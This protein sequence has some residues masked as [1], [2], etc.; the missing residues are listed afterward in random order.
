MNIK[1]EL[2]FI[3]HRLVAEIKCPKPKLYVNPIFKKICKKSLV[4]S[5][6]IRNENDYLVEWLDHHLKLGIKLIV[7]YDNAFTDEDADKTKNLISDYI[8]NNYVIYV[9]WPDLSGLRIGTVNIPK[10]DKINIAEIAHFHFRRYLSKHIGSRYFLKL[11]TDEFIYKLDGSTI[12]ESDLNYGITRIVGYNFGSSGLIKFTK[13]KVLTK[14]INRSIEANHYKAINSLDTTK[15]IYDAHEDR[16]RLR[17]KIY[18]FLFNRKLDEENNHKFMLNHYRLKSK[19]EFLKRRVFI[20]KGYTSGDYQE[21]SFDQLDRTMNDV[22]D[23]RIL[24]LY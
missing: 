18:K 3:K 24:D 5:T 1:K 12:E 2:L 8:K 21:N 20:P 9:R 14:F 4:I 22:R 6:C 11:D 16:L 10:V 19:E 15:W 7:V 17:Y 23:T 13:E